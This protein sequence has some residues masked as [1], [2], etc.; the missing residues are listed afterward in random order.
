MS[1]APKTKLK[2]I[3]V[4]GLECLRCGHTWSPR[5]PHI[6]MCAKCKSLYW[7]HASVP[8]RKKTA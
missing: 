2:M 4:K 3:T 1:T 5:I 8:P 6:T 7:N